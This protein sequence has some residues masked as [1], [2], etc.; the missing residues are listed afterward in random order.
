M[1]NVVVAMRPATGG[2]RGFN[3]RVDAVYR[4]VVGK[5]T[6]ALRYEQLKRNYVKREADLMQKIKDDALAADVAPAG[7][8]GSRGDLAGGI[9]VGVGPAHR[10]H[11]LQ[12][13]SASPPRSGGG[14]GSSRVALDAYHERVLRTLAAR[15]LARKTR[16]KLAQQ[17]IFVAGTRQAPQAQARH[18]HHTATFF[19][20]EVHHNS[21]KEYVGVSRSLN[22]LLAVH[23]RSVEQEEYVREEADAP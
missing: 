13:L 16:A 6:A 8:H 12:R 23:I 7:P 21:S 3:A 2:A 11:G 20:T 17:R 18:H 9:G 1:F 22:S 19:S 4:E 15:S 5:L 10:H 14:G